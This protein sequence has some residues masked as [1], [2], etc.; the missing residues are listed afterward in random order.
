MKTPRY[1]YQQASDIF[2]SKKID[3]VTFNNNQHFRVKAMF[4]YWFMLINGLTYKLAL[5]DLELRTY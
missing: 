4:D 2:K 1:T 5:V 3:F